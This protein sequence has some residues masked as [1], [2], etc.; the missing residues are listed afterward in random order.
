MG[1]E[2][3]ATSQEETNEEKIDND[4]TKKRIEHKILDSNGDVKEFAYLSIIN[5]AS[6][7]NGNFYFELNYK[8]LPFFVKVNQNIC[9]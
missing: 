8:A 3:V 5:E 6:Y 7:N 4:I 1:Q 2:V 9:L